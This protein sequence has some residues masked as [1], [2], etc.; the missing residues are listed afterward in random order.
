MNR[1]EEK[2][3]IELL[4]YLYLTIETMEEYNFKGRLKQLCNMVKREAESKVMKSMDDVINKDEEFVNNALKSKS[5]MVKQI[6]SMNEAEQVI[7]S[8]FTNKFFNNKEIAMKKGVAFFD[9]II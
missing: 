2:N 6:S 3:G 9:K 8:E 5:R 1:Q 4:F 7:F